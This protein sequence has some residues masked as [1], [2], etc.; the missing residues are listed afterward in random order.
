MKVLPGVSGRS[1]RQFTKAAA[2]V[3]RPPSRCVSVHIPGKGLSM[4]SLTRLD[5]ATVGVALGLP[6]LTSLIMMMWAPGVVTPTNYAVVVA[7]LLATA[8]IALNSWKSAQ[9]TG[10]MGQLLYETESP[11]PD[12]RK[13]RS[14]LVSTRSGMTLMGVSLATS[15]AL[16][17][18]C[19]TH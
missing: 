7:L 12:Q 11:V 1:S 4:T 5:R 14:S 17:L 8:A 19:V 6:C 3:L 18:L 2:V 13:R 16:V 15:A 9:G 10:S